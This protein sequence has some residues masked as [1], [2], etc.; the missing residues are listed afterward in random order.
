MVA[1]R[2]TA[3]L[4]ARVGPPQEIAVPATTVLGDWYASPLAFGH[5]R[6]VL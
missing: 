6:F 1:L 3:R 2:C 4:L 5:K